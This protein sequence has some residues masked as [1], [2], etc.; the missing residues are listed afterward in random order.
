MKNDTDT[1]RYPLWIIT[2]ETAT[3]WNLDDTDNPNAGHLRPVPRPIE[4]A[5]TLRHPRPGVR[6]RLFDDDSGLYFEGRFYGNTHSSAAFSPLDWAMCDSGCTR[7]D[8]Y[9]PD[10]NGRQGWHTL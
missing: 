9:G 1:A 10:A 3:A 4:S 2:H 7:I 6:F 8:Y 5:R